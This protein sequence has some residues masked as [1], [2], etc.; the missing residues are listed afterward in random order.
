[1]VLSPCALY[2]HEELLVPD[3][4]AAARRHAQHHALA[5]AV[6]VGIEQAHFRAFLR[7]SARARFTA[8]VDLP[9]PPLPEA[10]AITCFTWAKPR[11][12]RGVETHF[13][14]QP[15]GVQVRFELLG[16]SILDPRRR[17]A[18]RDGNPAAAGQH[19][20]APKPCHGLA[21]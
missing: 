12:G 11:L 13:E 2:R 8:V 1:M 16:Q 18:E 19:P 3:L 5:R 21:R 6:D 4:R 14:V 7:S 10:T 17:V 20:R 15:V 9:T